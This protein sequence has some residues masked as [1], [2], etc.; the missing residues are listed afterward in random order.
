MYAM[1]R[2]R[3]VYGGFAVCVNRFFSPQLTSSTICLSRQTMT[4]RLR[5]VHRTKERR[6]QPKKIVLFS[7]I[8]NKKI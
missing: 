3:C 7:K 1:T 2:L 5:S 8:V 6:R 4:Q